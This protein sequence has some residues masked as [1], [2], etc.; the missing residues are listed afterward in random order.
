MPTFV[1]APNGD[2]EPIV[3]VGGPDTE[4]LKLAELERR[5]QATERRKKQ[6]ALGDMPDRRKTI[7]ED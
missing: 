2:L 5:R 7:Q 3:M 6:I 1:V 4:A